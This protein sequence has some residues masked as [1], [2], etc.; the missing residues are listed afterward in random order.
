MEILKLICWSLAPA[1]STLSK[2]KK[3]ILKISGQQAFYSLLFSSLLKKNEIKHNEHINN[4]NQ[5]VFIVIVINHTF[6][7]F[8]LCLLCKM[9]F[10]K[11]Y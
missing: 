2:N 11:K 5:E 10:F 1:D 7:V 8:P 3:I 4:Q 9:I 6:G